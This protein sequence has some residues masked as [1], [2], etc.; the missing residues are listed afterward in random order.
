MADAILTRGLGLGRPLVT[1]GLG[2][3]SIPS[4]TTLFDDTFTGTPGTALTGQPA[5]PT[6]NG[7]N[8]YTTFSAFPAMVYATGGGIISA[9]FSGGSAFSYY[10][11]TG[12]PQDITATFQV[13]FLASSVGQVQFHRDVPGNN[14]LALSL[15]HGAQFLAVDQTVS[16]TTTRLTNPAF[17]WLLNTTYTV[18][19]TFAGTSFS[20]TV[21]DGTTT[22]NLITGLTVATNTGT[23]IL[24]GQS[25]GSVGQFQFLRATVQAAVAA[26]FAPG[27]VSANGTPGLTTIPL[28]VTG[29]VAGTG[30]LHY[31]WQ[32][33]PFG[34]GSFAN[35]SGATSATLTDTGLTNS[36]SYDY[37]CNVTDDGAGSGTTATFSAATLW[38]VN[39]SHL[40]YTPG[41]WYTPAGSPPAYTQAVRAGSEIAF[42]FTGTSCS[43]ILDTT[44]SGFDPTALIVNSKVDAGTRAGAN[45]T[46]VFPIAT[47]L[48]SGTHLALVSDSAQS[49]GVDCWTNPTE[50]MKLTG[51]L[52][53]P[54]AS[55][56]AGATQPTSLI[57]GFGDS[58]TSGVKAA[59]DGVT[60]DYFYSYLGI[61]ASN[62]SARACFNG[63]ASSGWT[64]TA[65]SSDVPPFASAF[66]FY[67]AG[68]ARTLTNL[69]GR[70]I[71][72]LGTNDGSGYSATVATDLAALRAALGAATKI[73]HFIPFGGFG[74]SDQQA[75]AASYGGTASTFA[76]AGTATYRSF[77]GDANYFLC[78]LGS[79]AQTGITGLGSPTAQ[80]ADGTHPNTATQAS[81]AAKATAL[82]QLIES[83]RPPTTITIT[84]PSSGV[85]GVPLTLTATL[86]NPAISGG[87][88]Y[89]PSGST[90]TEVFSPNPV[91][92]SQGAISSTFTVTAS[93]AVTASIGGTAS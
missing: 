38:P 70:A 2:S 62:L 40:N 11:L 60:P 89:V 84:G 88:T 61:V 24:I 53:D 45:P 19:F 72:N 63:F 21:S 26:T 35:V 90:G 5:S 91:V 8:V 13:R 92:F 75:G 30:S 66:G 52:L 76:G 1:R 36:T 58:I 18:T 28:Q 27:S 16:D 34:S 49:S 44:A 33:R 87:I 6:N 9:S 81:L 43:L 23:G 39:D 83:G 32:R 59:P 7:S 69:Y 56:V 47:G 42:G 82:I 22:T 17:A 29:A 3:S 86:D 57:A 15:D 10:P 80:S 79:D 54:G 41:N 4:L 31:Q 55:L 46:A 64:V 68:K 74:R 51:I 37:R 12:S 78:D 65:S 48:S 73:Y 14:D 20:A 85:V 77:S 93:T 71:V 50:S 25:G 67:S